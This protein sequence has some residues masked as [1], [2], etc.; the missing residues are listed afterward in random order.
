MHYLFDTKINSNV[1]EEE[2][3]LHRFWRNQK[4]QIVIHVFQ[5]EWVY[6]PNP[7]VSHMN[8]SLKSSLTRCLWSQHKPTLPAPSY[9][10]LPWPV[11]WGHDRRCP[12][13]TKTEGGVDNH[14][15]RSWLAPQCDSSSQW[16]H[17]GGNSNNKEDCQLWLMIAGKWKCSSDW[18]K[19]WL[20]S[21]SSASRKRER[22]RNKIT[23]S[24]PVDDGNK[25]AVRCATCLSF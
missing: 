12:F 17:Q 6:N 14:T 15:T 5:W 22:N 23:P 1:E 21:V 24:H 7:R 3:G 10:S 2:I 11:A 19:K 13:K 25:G 9:Q 8:S 16:R 18:W 20:F 4:P